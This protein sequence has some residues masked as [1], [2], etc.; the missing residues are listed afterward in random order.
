MWL[1]NVLNNL[2]F[3]KKQI[4]EG[5]LTQSELED[6][7]RSIVRSQEFIDIARELKIAMNNVS[8]L[9]KI[10]DTETWTILK[11]A[12]ESRLHSLVSDFLNTNSEARAYFGLIVQVE[13]SITGRKELEIAYKELCRAYDENKNSL[14]RKAEN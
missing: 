6:N 14:I 3:W 1:S 8:P 7:L 4:K 10:G 2:A 5:L 9:S 13:T 11:Q 12:I